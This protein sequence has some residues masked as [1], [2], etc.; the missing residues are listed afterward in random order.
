MNNTPLVSVIIP[1]YNAGAW[2]DEAIKSVLHQTYTNWEIIL[3][4]DGSLKEDT[5]IAES[6][7]SRFPERLFFVQHD[8]HVNRGSTVSRNTGIQHAQ[9]ERWLLFWMQMIFG[10]RKS[11]SINWIFFIA[12]RKCLWFA[13]H[14]AFGK[15]RSCTANKTKS[16][17]IRQYK[18]KIGYCIDSV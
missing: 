11:C 2:L 9:G 18:T 17:C 16:V 15:K 14:L 10:Y 1:F 4:D 13:K 5:A 3:I 12:V 7:A 6:Y 8:G